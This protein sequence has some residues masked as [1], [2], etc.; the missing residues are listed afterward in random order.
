MTGEILIA[1]TTAYIMA[2]IAVAV[3][4]KGRAK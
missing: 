4:R 1:A 2:L 3:H